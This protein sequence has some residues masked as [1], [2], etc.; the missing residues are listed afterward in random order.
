MKRLALPLLILVLAFLVEPSFSEP[1]RFEHLTINDGLPENSVRAIIQ[2]QFGFLWFATQNGVARYDGTGMKTY[3]PN[4]ADPHSLEIRFVLAMAEDDTGSIWMGSFS[5]GVSLY[6]PVRERFTN[7][8][9][10]EGY[11]GPGIATIRPTT[12][13][14]WFTSTSGGLYRAVGRNFE[15]IPV[16]PL[17]PVRQFGFTGLDVTSRE[18]WVGSTQNGLAHLERTTGTWRILRSDPND[19]ESLPSDF[20]T[21]IF[22]D[23]QGR[24]W[25]G[26]RSGLALHKGDGKFTIFKPRPDLGAVEPNYLVCITEDPSDQLWIGAAIGLYRFDPGTGK[27]VH[28]VHDPDKPGSPVLGPVL[29]I[30]SDQSGIIWAGSWHTGLNKY[31]PGSAK[32][33]VYLHDPGDPFSLDENAIGSVFE[34]SRANLWVGTGPRTPTGRG[35]AINR[36]RKGER[37]F[38]RIPF[39]GNEE[40][41]VGTVYSMVEDRQGDL[42]LGTNLGIWQFDESRNMVIRPDFLAEAPAPVNNGRI[43]DMEIDQAGRIWVTVWLAGIHRFDPLTGVWK[44]FR[45]D[46][47]DPSSLMG[48][49][50]SAVCLDASGGFWLGS[51]KA[52]LQVFEPETDTFRT[53]PELVGEMAS[54]GT[55]VPAGGDRVLV[56]TG[57]GILLC[58]PEGIIRT[59]TTRTGLPSDYAGEIILDRNNDLWVSTGLGLARTDLEGEEVIVFDER[60]GLPRNELYFAS[61]L[62]RSG[63]IFFGGH[64]GLVSFHPDSLSQKDFV[65]PVHITDIRIH[66]E[67]LAVGPESPLQK[68]L[69]VT[70][71]LNLGPL[72]NDLSLTFASLDY[73][74]PER[75]RYRYRL[76]P[77]DSDWREATELNAAHYTNLDPGT[78]LF[79]VMGSNSDGLWND[80]PATLRIVIDPPWYRTNWANFLYV[81][82]ILLFIVGVYRQLLNRERMR[83]ALEIERAEASHLQNLDQLKSRFFTNISHE[84]RTPLTLLMSPLKRL[85]EDPTSGS[86]ELFGTMARN[87][88]RLGRLIDQ[89]LDLSRLEADRMPARWRHGDWCQYLKALTSSFNALAEQRGIVLSSNWPD[90]TEPAWYDPDLLDKVLVNL[91]SNALK[92]THTGG[93]ITLTVGADP[94]IHPHVW[95]GQSEETELEGEARIMNLTVRN[96]GSHIPLEDI[97]NVFDRFH[98]VAENTDFGDLGSGIGLALVKELAEW[99]GGKVGVQS[100]MLTGTTFTV[101]LPL[102]QSA[103]PG[104]MIPAKEE[105][106][107]A[108]EIPERELA[109]EETGDDLEDQPDSELPS[110]LLVEDNA[111]LRNYVR[112]ELSDEY[113]VLVAVNGKSGLE[114]AR[115]EIPDLVL[116]DVMM[117]VMDGLELCRELKEGDLTNHVPVILLTAKAETS[118]RKEGLQI[119]ADDYV[120]KPFDMEELRIRIRNLIEQRRLLAERYNQLEVARPGRV[121]NPVPSAD[122]RFLDKVR[123][124][125]AANLEDPDFR[126]DGLCRE[127]GMSRTQLHRKLKAVS[128]RSAGDFLRAERL[129]KA[130]E[131]LSLGENNVTGIAYSVGYRS[132]SQFAKAF[133]EQFGMAPSDFEA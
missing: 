77:Q 18:I 36:Q 126:V 38:D 91:L 85:Q 64:S 105:D 60:D 57:A 115:R 70:E 29:S 79:S 55:I 100:D 74:H 95:P 34:D 118:S 80:T 120:A 23:R 54:V 83:M 131:M 25:V 125:I 15:Q 28:H 81:L 97:D 7:F 78:Y 46:P 94:D 132:L 133:R 9:A 75:N 30:H 13:G 47:A 114:L 51:D 20:I 6:D 48:D 92:F 56:S 107:Q 21:F 71:T 63:R 65:P 89:L 45:A 35:G 68:S 39:P 27:F 66:D 96:T 106:S 33:E 72:Q 17:H 53:V 90:R 99:C 40:N 16:P 43:L 73:A 67:P 108:K 52:G 109:P 4:P 26:S 49:D 3:L 124:I 110:V 69:R 127:I 129:N 12:D 50:L 121:S 84:F 128:G 87:A 19:P 76:E 2:D 116:S 119:G 88:R 8:P 11:P 14:V 112:E 111:D 122:D 44:S 130:A 62:T 59:Y 32:F 93:E 104:E 58:E 61:F 82:G 103:P 1:I 31:D 86:P 101:A 123:E 10:G 37:G 41:R 117:P 113:Q 102:Y 22:R 42:W 5:G 24:V 98:Q